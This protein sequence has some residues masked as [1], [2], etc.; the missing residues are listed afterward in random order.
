MR[1]RGVEAHQTL[2][3]WKFLE[4]FRHSTAAATSFPAQPATRR[5]A[6]LTSPHLTCTSRSAPQCVSLHLELAGP[7]CG[8]H[9]RR[10]T[11]GSVQV[12][13]SKR[14]ASERSS[15]T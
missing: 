8:S 10:S 9:D 12:A 3:R 7:S 1:A 11:F 14:R 4:C 2:P 13:S 15:M 5:G 6:H